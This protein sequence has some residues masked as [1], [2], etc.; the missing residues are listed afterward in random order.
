MLTARTN[1]DS[2]VDATVEVRLDEDRPERTGW[3]S[4]PFCCYECSFGV[5]VHGEHWYMEMAHVAYETEGNIFKGITQ[6]EI[7][8][9][10]SR[11]ANC[12]VTMKPSAS[13]S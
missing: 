13:R 8:R 3:R 12:S 11:S 1:T 6:G 2:I 4:D 10:G 9:S 7:F 5:W